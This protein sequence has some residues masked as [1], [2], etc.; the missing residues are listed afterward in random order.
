MIGSSTPGFNDHIRKSNSIHHPSDRITP[1]GDDFM[2]AIDL[3]LGLEDME[4]H[5]D[6]SFSA[7]G[8]AF[9]DIPGDFN[10]DQNID[11]DL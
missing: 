4:Q 7:P 2:P 1:V 6:T 3:Q 10:L 11:L 5:P 8:E 9:R